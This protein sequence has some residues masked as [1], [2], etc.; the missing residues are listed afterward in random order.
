MENNTYIN[1]LVNTHFIELQIGQTMGVTVGGNYYNNVNIM[2][3]QCLF[4]FNAALTNL[5][6][7]NE[8]LINSVLDD[9]YIIQAANNLII[10][11]FFVKNIV[12][13]GTIT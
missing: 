4:Y 3:G 6:I 5:P 1:N 13:T 7:N 12:N 2:N 9:L 11:N 8:T 10:S